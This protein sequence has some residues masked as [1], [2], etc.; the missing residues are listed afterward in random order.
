MCRKYKLLG[1]DDNENIA[2]ALAFERMVGWL[3]APLL[4]ND[5]SRVEPL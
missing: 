5:A 3:A 2:P 1:G 4:D